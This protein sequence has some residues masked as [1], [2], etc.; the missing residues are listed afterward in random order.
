MELGAAG[1]SDDVASVDFLSRLFPKLR[2]DYNML[3]VFDPAHGKLGDLQKAEFNHVGIDVG[4][5]FHDFLAPILDPIAAAL[6]PFQPIIEVL[7]T[8]IPVVSDIAGEP[9]TLIDLATSYFVANGTISPET[10]DFI[11]QAARIAALIG[12]LDDVVDAGFIDFGGVD[13]KTGDLRNPNFSLVD[14]RPHRQDQ[15]AGDLG[16]RP[17]R[18]Q[19]EGLQGQRDP[20]SRTSLR[21]TRTTTAA[22]C[23]SRCSTTRWPR[24]ACCS[25]S[26]SRCSSTS[27]PKM[28][29]GYD[30]EYRWPT[31]IFVVPTPVGPIPIFGGLTGG[32]HVGAQLGFGY[33]TTGLTD[34]AKSNDARDILNGFFITD[35]DSA[36]KDRKELY[37]SGYLGAFAEADL[38]FVAAGAEGGVNA[39]VGLNLH[40]PNNDGKLHGR[41]FFDLLALGGPQCLFDLQGDLSLLSGHLRQDQ[42]AVAAAGHQAL[43]ADRAGDH[44]GLLRRVPV[45]PRAGARHA[46]GR[47]YAAAQHGP[48]R[49]PAPA[50]QYHRRRRGVRGQGAV[51]GLGAGQ[52]VRVH[53]DL[54]AAGTV[55]R[56]QR[57]DQVPAEGA[58]HLRRRRQ[59]QRHH[60]HR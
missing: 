47:R 34:F 50:R 16:E 56:S 17:A 41:E 45:R 59:R 55:A 1:S 30:F 46:A 24:S 4:T 49:G 52:G 21:A 35:W 29:F 18:D 13:L 26:P 12:T 10:A 42:A 28:E 39:T 6:E 53:A 19:R 8:P 43:G 58:A 2:A 5:L 3:W 60:R 11:V 54:R 7:N 32:I 40:D 22:S 23:R 57:P 36:G 20:S 27:C 14:V 15:G 37:I 31:P 51:V 33:D 48:A 44:A 25:A 38:V 9:I